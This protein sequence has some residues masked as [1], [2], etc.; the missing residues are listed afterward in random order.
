[1]KRFFIT[2]YLLSILCFPIF[3]QTTVDHWE[4]AVY[5]TTTWRYFP[6]NSNPGSEWKDNSFSDASWTEGKG[7]FGYGDNDDNTIIEGISSVFVRKTFTITDT[8]KIADALLNVDYDDG[9]VAY[10]N[11][12]EIARSNMSQVSPAYSDFSQTIH[13]A[14]IY[15]GFVPESFSIKNKLDLFKNG[16][17]ILAIQ[18]HNSDAMSS[19]LTL[20][21]FLSFGI[22]DPAS[23]FDE[24]PFWF[25]KPFVFE[26][27]NLPILVINT[28]GQTIVDD[29]EIIADMGIIDNGF[30]NRNKV[31][32]PFNDYEGKISIEVRGESS[33]MFPK[34][35]FKV[36]TLNNSAQADTAVSLLG[37]PKEDNWVLYAP[38]S[39]KS[40]LRNVL[41][42]DLGNKMGHYATRTKF[43]EVVL[44]GEYQGVY[45]LME[46]IKQ[47]KNRVDI[48]K[49][50]NKDIDGDDLT[51][52]YI[53]RVDKIDWN[54][55]PA[56]ESVPVPQLPNEN[57]ISF[58]FFDP[59]GEDLLTAQKQYIKDYIFEF[60]SSLT[61]SSF[62][63]ATG[64]KKYIDI[65]SFVDYILISELNK[66]VD[67]YQYS[68]YMHKDKDSKGGKLKMGPIW[69]Y[70]LAF[71]NV[72]YH[73]NSQ[74]APGWMYNDNYRMFWFRRM[75]SDPEFA[76][77]LYCRWLELRK[78]IFS[79]DHIHNWIDSTA[80]VLK[81]A[82]ERNYKKWPILGTYIWPN[83]HVANSYENEIVFLKEWIRKRLVWMDSNLPKICQESPVTGIYEEAKEAE[84]SVYPNPSS[85]GFNFSF[86]KANK[87]SKLQVY[88]LSGKLL[89]SNRINGTSY[90]WDG[91]L[92]NGTKLLPGIFLYKIDLGAKVITGKIITH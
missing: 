27:S 30:G 47:D 16:E 20:R 64:Y 65:A 76:G 34:K 7:G 41:T 46:K 4:T 19:D 63:D 39:D 87:N 68:T 88:N 48:A 86:Q 9:F 11:G 78:G 6:G 90:F 79:T 83:Q 80:N 1:M 55:Y 33:Q 61:K 8:S 49:L 77:N 62:R 18:V 12:T 72:D 23:Y 15:Q 24:T 10:L 42:Y 57:N 45:V 52:G 32:D 44:N 82:Q 51:G 3:S 70:N 73:A 50:T 35:S 58:Q 5:D 84:I 2:I 66:N 74:Y 56:W 37:F 89:F 17:N 22:A 40:M 85:E 21:A 69:D 36:K 28:N 25:V 43:C 29:P 75:M 38:Y 31:A 81:E 14:S 59:D 71:G 91:K 26:S 13:E 92:D 67:A 53:L 54:D 60:Q